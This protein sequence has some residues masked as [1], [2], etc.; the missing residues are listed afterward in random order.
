MQVF[1]VTQAVAWHCITTALRAESDV[2]VCVT[3]IV[4]VLSMVQHNAV[5]VG[6]Y[7]HFH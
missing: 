7:K 4:L 1:P 5:A 3:D 2:F 6:Q